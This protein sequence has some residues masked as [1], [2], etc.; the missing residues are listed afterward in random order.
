MVRAIGPAV[1]CVKEIGI[2][3]ERLTAPTV[4]LIPTMPQMLEGQ[5]MDPSVSV[6]MAAAHRLA[7]AAAPDPEL[8]P[9]GLQI[10][11]AHV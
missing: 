5:T 7:A 4:G 3:P 9:H 10:G 6:P 1:S 8:D 11:R 2:I